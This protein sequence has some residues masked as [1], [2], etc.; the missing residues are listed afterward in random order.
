MNNTNFG[1]IHNEY[2]K[3]KP[4]EKIS[5]IVDINRPNVSKNVRKFSAKLSNILETERTKE[6]IAFRC[7]KESLRSNWASPR[8]RNLKDCSRSYRKC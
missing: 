7:R 2:E 6:P 1:K 5:E 4:I 3:G 8:K